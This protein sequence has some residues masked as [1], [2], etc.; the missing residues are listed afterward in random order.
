VQTL[1]P[2]VTG[3]KV[4]LFPKGRRINDACAALGIG[5]SSIYKLRA[6]GKIKMVSIAG[7]TI[8]PETEI[9]RLATEG[10]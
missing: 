7:R 4:A 5:R 3:K 1:E 9:E 2:N 6:Q 10:A 8:V